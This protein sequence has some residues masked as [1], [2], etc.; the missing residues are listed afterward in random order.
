MHTQ[1]ATG[2]D[3]HAPAFAGRPVIDEHGVLLGSVTDVIYDLR[4]N[5]PE[6]LVVDPGRFR[7]ARYVP[8]T[9]AYE[10]DDGTIVIPW[11]RH[12]FK[13]APKAGG[14]HILTSVDRRLLEVHFMQQAPRVDRRRL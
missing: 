6:Y 3:G 2:H 14:D 4:G 12:W 7:F 1:P 5:Q 13:L 10:A 9:G 11:D 8:V